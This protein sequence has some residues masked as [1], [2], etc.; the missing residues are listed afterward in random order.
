MDHADQE[1]ENCLESVY[2]PVRRSLGGLRLNNSSY[3]ELFTVSPGRPSTTFKLR[4]KHPLR[5]TSA[6]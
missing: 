4:G 2:D 5:L 3:T 6:P 1:L